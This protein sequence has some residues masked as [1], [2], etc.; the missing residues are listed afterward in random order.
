MKPPIEKNVDHPEMKNSNTIT[1][2]ESLSIEKQKELLT[3][4]SA[5][6]FKIY[7]NTKTIIK[8]RKE[9]EYEL[10]HALK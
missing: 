7:C 3:L 2:H 5:E 6:Y 9:L 10:A 4:Y 1:F 8:T